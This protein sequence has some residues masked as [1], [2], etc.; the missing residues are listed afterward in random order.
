MI[1]WFS[2]EHCSGGTSDVGK[3]TTLASG[4]GQGQPN[5]LPQS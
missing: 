5:T 1:A 2:V 4:E 3:K